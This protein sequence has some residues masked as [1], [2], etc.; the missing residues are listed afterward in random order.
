MSQNA[1]VPG[2]TSS[3]ENCTWK[4]LHM[5]SNDKSLTLDK[6]YP[7]LTYKIQQLVIGWYGVNMDNNLGIIIILLYMNYMEMQVDTK[8]F[9]RLDT[10]LISQSKIPEFRPC[11]VWFIKLEIT[12]PFTSE[13]SKQEKWVGIF[14]ESITCQKNKQCCKSAARA[15]LSWFYN[16][17]IYIYI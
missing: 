3:G 13:H 8:Y 2:T 11:M 5:D 15:W 10:P 4:R 14:Q 9:S 6:S 1:R 7:N 16:W 12:H 17:Y